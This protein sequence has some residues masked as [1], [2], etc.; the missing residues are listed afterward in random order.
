MYLVRLF[1]SRSLQLGYLL[2]PNLI[3]KELSGEVQNY[4][5]A[6]TSQ[7]E[8]ELHGPAQHL[9]YGVDPEA[10]IVEDDV[11]PDE[12]HDQEGGER[13]DA[14]LHRGVLAEGQ[15]HLQHD[16]NH[17]IGVHHMV[18][19]RGE[20]S[21]Q[22]LGEHE[23]TVNGHQAPEGYAHVHG[24]GEG[25]GAEHKVLDAADCRHFARHILIRSDEV[26]QQR[27]REVHGLQDL[28]QVTF[29]Y[30]YCSALIILVQYNLGG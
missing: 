14:A 12:V 7:V 22:H 17:D 5:K 24:D 4:S 30:Y 6:E 16:E 27:N 18:E 26:I 13:S 25:Q 29:Y 19:P 1:L 23:L 10:G 28:K 15:E 20:V 21:I 3:V 8:D 9:Q 2:G 11:H